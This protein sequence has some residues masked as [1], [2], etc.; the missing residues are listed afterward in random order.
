M[1]SID[2]RVTE[3]SHAARASST[4]GSRQ[5]Q[6]NQRL[7]IFLIA[8]VAL[9]PV[10]LGGARPLFWAI[11]GVVIAV[12]GLIYSLA[13]WRKR[14]NFRV[15]LST[16]A[17]AIIPWCFVL[18]A[19]VVQI[20]PLGAT[21]PIIFTSFDGEAVPSSTLSLAPGETLLMILRMA[22][23][24]C[25]FFLA[26]Q[27]ASNRDR[28]LQ[29]AR[30][31]CYLVAAHAVYGLV[32]LTQFGDPMLLVE[33]WAYLGSATGTFVNRNSYATFLA[34]GLVTATGLSLRTLLQG[35]P[36]HLRK[37]QRKPLA[38]AIP[39]MVATLV[40]LAALFASESR[41]GL[42]AGLVGAG[43][44]VSVGL[45]KGSFGDRKRTFSAI[46][47]A[48]AVLG[49]AL[50]LFSGGT[51][52]RLGSVERDGDVRLQLYQQV[53]EM[54]QARWLTGYGGGSFEV[55]YPLFHRAPVSPDLVWHKAHSTYLT[56]WSELGVLAGTLPMLIF[57]MFAF[58]ALR[59]VWIRQADW[60]LPLI[61]MSALLVI[62]IHSLVDFSMEISG[63]VYLVLLVVA[64][65]T[66]QRSNGKKRAHSVPVA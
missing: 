9:A 44:V 31:T 53:W 23:Y 32:A 18:A 11:S 27:V 22:G 8:F 35:G 14:E 40:I 6:L 63:N 12:G 29:L 49:T 34:V 26:V 7:A 33:K 36:S 19:L 30:W 59:L 50:L 20:L 25:F 41:M 28:A 1:S 16:L 24:G 2:L 3:S 66:A 60:W 61:T 4:S 48:L 21:N 38:Q 15:G 64:L 57:A 55:A 54:I 43:L 5:T 13:I 65:G 46:G 17:W 37:G 62:G 52:E 39:F 10:P 42:F 58:M 51:F 45:A 47:V 56:L